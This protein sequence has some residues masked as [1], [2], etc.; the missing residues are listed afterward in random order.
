MSDLKKQFDA[1]IA[2]LQ[3]KYGTRAEPP[4][5]E[6]PPIADTLDSDEPF[7][8]IEQITWFKDRIVFDIVREYEDE[9][10]V[11]WTQTLPIE[12]GI[13]HQRLQVLRNQSHDIA[14]AIA[15]GEKVGVRGKRHARYRRWRSNVGKGTKR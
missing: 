2:G 4:A 10:I 11:E 14:R 12:N 8:V 6:D 5:K 15:H 13:N 7:G 1:T 3:K 9:D